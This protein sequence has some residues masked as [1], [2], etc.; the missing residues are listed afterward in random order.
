M[1][2]TKMVFIIGARSNLSIKLHDGIENSVLI[3][4]KELQNSDNFLI[5]Y[6]H[7]QEMYFIVNAFYPANKLNDISKP[8]KY[9]QLS[10][11]LLA[12][13]LQNIKDI[14]NKYN[15]K[16]MKILYTS[17]ASIYGDNTNC[18][19]KNH[20]MP[21]SLHSSLKVSSEFLLSKFCKEE[22]I[23]Y[24][25]A[26]IFNM[27][28]GND[29][30]SV[31]FKIINAIKNNQSISLINDG[32]ALRDFIH[33]NDVV[34][35]YQEL[36]HNNQYDI[37]N[38][39]NGKAISVNEILQYLISKKI[40]IN[41]INTNREEINISIANIDRLNKIIDVDKFSSVFSFLDNEI[42]KNYK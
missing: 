40:N 19:E 41:T 38:I 32:K 20:P 1:I 2:K 35:S 22:N 15:I 42:I 17:S 8:L 9:I 33:I 7:I 6:S 16:I 10:V 27:Y 25:I 23:N 30:F 4:S 5:K 11:Y 28:G 29:K 24:T 21:L 18:S 39:A 26:R 12:N 36:L 14:K 37:V 3:S 13:L 34:V 31:I